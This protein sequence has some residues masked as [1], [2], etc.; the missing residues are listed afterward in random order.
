MEK[1]A[2]TASGQG[3]QEGIASGQGLPVQ[4]FGREGRRTCGRHSRACPPVIITSDRLPQSANSG[5]EIRYSE[6][7]HTAIAPPGTSTATD[8]SGFSDRKRLRHSKSDGVKK[9]VHLRDKYNLR[10]LGVSSAICASG[11]QASSS[12]RPHSAKRR[13]LR[14]CSASTNSWSMSFTSGQSRV[15]SASTSPQCLTFA[16]ICPAPGRL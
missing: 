11:F 16:I 8:H 10:T 9:W 5:P 1:S 7:R 15:S 14:A 12:E 6:S 2:S 13:P 3:R 4:R